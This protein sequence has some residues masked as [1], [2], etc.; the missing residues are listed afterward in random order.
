ME[1]LQSNLFTK[2]PNTALQ[3]CL[4]DNSQHITLTKNSTGEHVELI[5]TALFRIKDNDPSLGIPAFEVNGTYDTA[6]AN[7]IL[8]YKEK[9][10]IVNRSYQNQADNKVG[11]MTLGRLDQEMLLLEQGRRGGGLEIP[12]DPKP[13]QKDLAAKDSTLASSWLSAAIGAIAS[14]KASLISTLAGGNAVLPAK[15]SEALDTHFHLIDPKPSIS[16]TIRRS[17]TLQDAIFIEITLIAI[18]G[19]LSNKANF[20]NST[21]FIDKNGKPRPEVPAH[22]PFG[23]HIFFNPPYKSFTDPKGQA[24]GPNSRAAILIHEATH[25]VIS[26]SGEDINHIS[27]FDAAYDNMNPNNMLHNSSSYASFAAMIATGHGKQRS[28]R[29]GLGPLRGS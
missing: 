22:A 14:Y 3:N 17:I 12:T 6:T 7:A 27:E 20:E 9:R 21:G 15:T 5:Q 23:G 19:V 16:G 4:N 8:K 13:V 25:V 11:K 24:I 2:K 29:F 26:D 18:Q 1:L 28:D 10:D